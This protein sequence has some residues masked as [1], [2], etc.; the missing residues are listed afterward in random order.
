[1]CVFAAARMEL[2]IDFEHPN[3]VQ[4][5]FMKVDPY[6][7]LSEHFIRSINL[8]LHPISSSCLS[9]GHLINAAILDIRHIFKR[10]RISFTSGN[11]IHNAL[12]L[13]ISPF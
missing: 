7:R 6:V 13:K 2:C 4:S 9:E 8:C 11:D 3:V 1:M 10:L 12:C 5:A